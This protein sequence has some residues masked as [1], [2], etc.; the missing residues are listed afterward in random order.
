MLD[1]VLI[2]CQP[3]LEDY[4]TDNNIQ[5][6]YSKQFGYEE[7][8]AIVDDVEYNPNH[9]VVDPDEQLCYHYGID[10]DQVNMMEL[11]WIVSS[12][13][14]VLQHCYTSSSKRLEHVN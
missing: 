6:S 1:S 2:H 3:E 5:W 7:L 9:D 10:Y 11:A 13:W 14:Y 8:D 12:S 4:L